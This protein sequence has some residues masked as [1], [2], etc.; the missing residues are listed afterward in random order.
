MVFAQLWEWYSPSYGQGRMPFAPTN[1]KIKLYL[2]GWG[3]L[4]KQAQLWAGRMP[5]SPYKP[6]NQIVSHWLRKAKKTSPAMGRANACKP[7][8]T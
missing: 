8:Q 7:L 2:T 1:L 3:K 6:E 5:A 4:K